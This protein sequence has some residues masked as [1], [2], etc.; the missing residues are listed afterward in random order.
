MENTNSEINTMPHDFR[1]ILRGK[2]EERCQQNP[3]YSLRAF[4]RDLKLS[5]SRLSEILSGK[6]GLSPN[7]AKKVSDSLGFN[8]D[9]KSYFCDLVASMHARSRQEREAAKLRLKKFSHEDNVHQLKLDAF[10][11]ISDWYHLAIL[12]L[13]NLKWFKNDTRWIAKTLGI[14]EIEAELAIER[15]IRVQLLVRKDDKL[16][17]L[18]GPGLIPGGIPSDSIKKFHTQILERGKQAIATQGVD[19][20][21]FGAAIIAVDKSKLKEAKEE[22]ENFQHRIC[23][24]MDESSNKD[25]LYCL[26]VQFYSLE[27]G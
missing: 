27:R 6:Q 24:L 25:G 14:T 1:Q 4:A 7:A 8:R 22:I 13:I 19:E 5:P 20:R 16:T 12:E 10:R 21:E 18:K 23:R 26:A 2:L 15:L 17:P 3:R 9:E 11:I